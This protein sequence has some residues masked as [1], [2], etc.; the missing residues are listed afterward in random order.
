MSVLCVSVRQLAWQ[1]GP[2]ESE[3]SLLLSNLCW[4]PGENHGCT[5]AALKHLCLLPD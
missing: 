5:P 2:P 3:S 1:D 4:K